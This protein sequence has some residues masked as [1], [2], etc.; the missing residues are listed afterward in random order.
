[1]DNAHDEPLNPLRL[2]ARVR[3]AA[4]VLERWRRSLRGDP[5]GAAEGVLEA[6]RDVAVRGTYGALVESSSPGDAQLREG[7]AEWVHALLQARVGAEY[8]RAVALAAAERS[9]P[10]P[11]EP[12]GLASYRDAWR[13]LLTAP[14]RDMAV[15]WRAVLEARGPAIAAAVRVHS[16]RAHEIALRLGRSS[17]WALPEIAPNGVVAAAVVLLAGTEELARATLK[18][19]LA[20]GGE[21]GGA[22]LVD[23]PRLALATDARDGWPAQLRVRWL[24]ELF[25][26]LVRGL[27]LELPP[28]PEA[29]GAA[30][31]ARALGSFGAAF[32]RAASAQLPFA[33][34]QSPAFVDAH[35]F[36]YAFASLTTSDTWARSVLGTSRAVARDQARALARSALLEARLAAVRVLCDRSATGHP[37]AEFAELAERFFGAPV[38]RELAGAWPLP[39]FDDAA[40]F[41]GLL[42]SVAM[43]A[44]LVER[45]DADWF[46][47]PRALTELRS[48]ASSP[49]RVPIGDLA[50]AA[51]VLAARFEQE[52]G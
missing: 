28:L 13:G 50:D 29:L 20:R 44:E 7:L 45:F 2:D 12:T 51:R 40:R 15:R 41:V 27:S 34:G 5:D 23:V 21:A 46:R 30:S 24:E 42:R 1:M 48:R 52:L 9:V 11:V 38:P 36:G 33:V 32:R 43:T 8:E 17:A 6:Y 26:P 19:A 22:Q 39:C 31:F 47:N 16:E 35:T 4:R 3:A 49:A 10:S 37:A 18:E 14:S 25:S